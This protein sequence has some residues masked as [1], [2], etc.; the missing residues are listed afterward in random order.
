MEEIP[1]AGIMAPQEKSLR[2]RG[3]VR[4]WM[5]KM[6]LGYLLITALVVVPSGRV[7]WVEGWFFAATMM[8]NVAALTAASLGKDTGLL[9]ERS[10]LQPGAKRWDIPLAT[11][12]ACLPVAILLL[13]GL[14]L[15]YG[16]EAPYPLSVRA[17]GGIL[18]LLGMVFLF[19]WAVLSNRFFSPIMRIQA[20][21]GHTVETGGPYRFVRHP[22]YASM[23][24]AYP[25]MALLLGFSWNLPVAGIAMIVTLVRTAREDRTLFAELPGYAE[26]A[27]RVR[28]RLVPGIW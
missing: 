5:G 26:Y 16:R 10:G 25:G 8:V 9:V 11:L 4:L 14:N 23:L 24:L 27:S 18:L 22:G 19:T 12:M 2:Q 6:V 3:S 28:F 7:D 15:R 13:A 20:D 21:R 1:S 17:L